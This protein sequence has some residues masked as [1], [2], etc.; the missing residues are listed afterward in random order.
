MIF[1]VKRYRGFPFIA[2]QKSDKHRTVLPVH[3]FSPQQAHAEE[4][5]DAVLHTL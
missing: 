4:Y 2:G 1:F 5:Q 3:S